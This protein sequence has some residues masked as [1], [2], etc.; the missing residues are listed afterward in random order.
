MGKHFVTGRTLC[1]LESQFQIIWKTQHCVRFWQSGY[2]TSLEYYETSR[3]CKTKLIFEKSA[4]FI[5][6][7][8][9]Q[10]IYHAKI[11]PGKI[12][13]PAN[14]CMEKGPT[15]FRA[16]VYIFFTDVPDQIKAKPLNLIKK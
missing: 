3:K 16:N 5:C 6:V 14:P 12:K 9:A 4:F 13:I 7:T 15:N 1:T 11:I 10:K 8:D 2:K